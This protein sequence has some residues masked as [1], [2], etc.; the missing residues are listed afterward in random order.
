[1][2]SMVKGMLVSAAGKDGGVHAEEAGGLSQ[3]GPQP[4][5]R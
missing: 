1:V 2:E 3:Q 4:E 5:S